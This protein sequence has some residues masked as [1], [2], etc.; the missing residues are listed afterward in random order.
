MSS[1]SD[2]D[3]STN[4]VQT[5]GAT[6]NGAL[7]PDDPRVT[8]LGGNAGVHI[9]AEDDEEQ[10]NPVEEPDPSIDFGGFVVSLGTSCMV[11]LGKQVNPETG[12]L[13]RDLE[14][15]R[16]TIDILEMLRDK[17]RGN[18]TDDERK[19]LDTL[20]DDLRSAYDDVAG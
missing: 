4:G 17:T 19:L 9:Q 8:P 11:N 1:S 18:L 2:D 3:N 16:Q 20:L 5:N 7:S 10:D 14:A 13:D 12:E 15:A 6:T